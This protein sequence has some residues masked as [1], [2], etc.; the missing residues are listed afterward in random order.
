MAHAAA[1]ARRHLAFLK[2]VGRVREKVEIAGVVVMHVRD[3]HVGHLR[4]VDADRPQALGR[5]PQRL[6]PAPA[7]ALRIEAGIDHIGLSGAD[8]RPD[9]IVERHRAVVRVAADEIRAREPLV[10]AIADRENLV[11]L[12]QA[13]AFTSTPAQ[14]PMHLTIAV[15]SLAGPSSELANYQSWRTAA[16][17]HLCTPSASAS[18]RQSLTSLYIRPVTQP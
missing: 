3:D 10:P 11:A 18:S 14:A 12:H 2:V 8:D 6:A 5:R 1:G 4:R 9:V 13:R 15:K 7:R 17:T 16:P